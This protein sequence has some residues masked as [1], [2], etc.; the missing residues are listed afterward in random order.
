MET[1]TISNEKL[2]SLPKLNI[3]SSITNEEGNIYLYNDSLLKTL[4]ITSGS[5]YENKIKNVEFINNNVVNIKELV[6]PKEFVN[7]DD[8]IIGFTMDYIKNVTNLGLILNNDEVCNKKKIDLLQKLGILIKKTSSLKKENIDFY[9]G[10]LHEY[11]FLTNKD[12]D[13]FAVDVDSVSLNDKY[14]SPS[15][16]L[17]KNKNIGNLITKYKTNV[18][19]ITYP[20]SN[21]DL[22]CYNMIILNSISNNK[23]SEMDLPEYNDYINYLK[24]LGMSKKLINSFNKIYSTEDNI[25]PIDYLYEINDDVLNNATKNEYIIYKSKH[26][27]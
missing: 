17:N 1:I 6:I 21:S 8:K 16:Y 18:Y 23:I 24:Y 7:M 9:F 25:N 10:D 5:N 19:G 26:L 20:S 22:L 13:I 3:D 4:Y 15:L 2:N 14:P 11:N 12:E 27:I